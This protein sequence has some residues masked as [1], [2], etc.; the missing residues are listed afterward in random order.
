MRKTE[1]VEVCWKKG[2]EKTNVSG[3]ILDTLNLRCLLNIQTERLSRQST[4]G[5]KF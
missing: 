3:Q 2:K 1:G 4:S 5:Q